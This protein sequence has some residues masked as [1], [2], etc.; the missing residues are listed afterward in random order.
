MSS[1]QHQQSG[2]TFSALLDNFRMGLRVLLDEM[3]ELLRA[4]IHA[5]DI[6]QIKKRMA[7]ELQILGEE[8]QHA[9]ATQNEE[10]HSDSSVSITERMDLAYRQ[11]D[12][13]QDEIKRLEQNF[14]AEYTRTMEKR[15]KR[16]M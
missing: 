6:R 14:H 3:Y 4:A 10:G 13:L 12:F 7:Q 9:R 16:C 1:S 11:V 8:F 5:H 2:M 15:R